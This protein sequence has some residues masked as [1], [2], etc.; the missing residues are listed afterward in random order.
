MPKMETER[1]AIPRNGQLS[2]KKKR[3]HNALE[4]PSP[5]T[6]P[7]LLPECPYCTIR[8]M[9]TTVL[10]P[11]AFLVAGSIAVILTIYMYR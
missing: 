9:D 4:A 5:R 8:I 2:R 10:I 7:P 6:C 3:I 11:V 1:S